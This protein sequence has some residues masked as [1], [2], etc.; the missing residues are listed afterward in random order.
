MT[1]S[2]DDG[3]S[4]KKGVNVLGGSPRRG[5]GHIQLSAVTVNP[6]SSRPEPRVFFDKPLA[7]AGSPNPIRSV[8]TDSSKV[9]SNQCQTS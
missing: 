4:S 6:L 8:A 3:A 1:C 7:Q 5:S 9:A 2:A